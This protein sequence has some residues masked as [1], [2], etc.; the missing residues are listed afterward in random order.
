M[1]VHAADVRGR[2]RVVGS[3]S[4]QRRHVSS[5]ARA[6]SDDARFRPAVPADA[7]V[8]AELR[9]EFRPAATPPAETREAF[10]NRCAHWMRWNWRAARGARGSRRR[11][12]AS[13]ARCGCK[14]SQKLPNPA[15]RAGA[16]RLSLEPLCARR[17]RAAASARACF[18]RRSTWCAIEPARSRRA[19]AVGA[20]R[21]RSMC[22]TG[23]ARAMTCM[24]ADIVF[25]RTH[26][27]IVALNVGVT[28]RPARPD[29]S[30]QLERVIALG[31]DVQRR[32][33]PRA[34]R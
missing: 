25:I 11:T 2:T 19:V 13:S 17:Q 8:L 20:Q 12:A 9:W 23:S 14:S 16:A 28:P 31:D 7:R 27:T 34:S 32:R 33:R 5:R 3:R 4:E 6:G 29:P 18:E 22:A 26:S 15:R 21:R 10:V 30:R 24:E 1:T